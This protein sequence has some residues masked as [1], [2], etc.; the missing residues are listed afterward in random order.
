MVVVGGGMGGGVCFLVAYCLHNLQNGS[1][2]QISLQNFYR[3]HSW[4][5]SSVID[6]LR[7][8]FDR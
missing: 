4:A 3:D 8:D 7:S 1:Q 2:G 6:A 5:R